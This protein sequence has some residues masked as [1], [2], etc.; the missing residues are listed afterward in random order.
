M[1]SEASRKDLAA[2]FVTANAKPGAVLSSWTC[3]ET[4]RKELQLV[5]RNEPPL[6]LPTVMSARA[7]KRARIRMQASKMQSSIQIIRKAQRQN[8]K[9]TKA[10]LCHKLAVS[11]CKTGSGFP[12]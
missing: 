10:E 2:L 1:A 6:G 11:S 7:P 9:T 3:A 12:T 8:L 4:G 5:G